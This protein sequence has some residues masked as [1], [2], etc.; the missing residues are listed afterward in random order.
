MI[1]AFVISKRVAMD[2][3][4][5]PKMLQIKGTAGVVKVERNK[6]TKQ[7]PL[8]LKRYLDYILK[9]KYK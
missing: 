5:K 9:T 8:F 3:Q 7:I 4:M 2:H 6:M 1:I